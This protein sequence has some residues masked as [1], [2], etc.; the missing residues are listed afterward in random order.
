MST[1][2]TVEAPEVD[3]PQD[4]DAATII[5]VT[6]PNSPHPIKLAAVR[7]SAD[8]ILFVGIGSLEVGGIMVGVNDDGRALVQIGSSAGD[9]EASV[10]VF[11]DL[12]VTGSVNAAD[13]NTESE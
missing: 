10:T 13:I 7:S 9:D 8:G 4:D 2:I 12:T 6:S 1:R 3:S 11:G 5:E